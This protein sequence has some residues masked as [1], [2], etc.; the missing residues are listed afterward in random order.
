M[1]QGSQAVAATTLLN[2]DTGH[3]L[4]KVRSVAVIKVPGAHGWHSVGVGRVSGRKYA[5]KEEHGVQ[6]EAPMGTNWGSLLAVLRHGMQRSKTAR[7]RRSQ[8]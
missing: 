5:P 8:A 3:A 7:D 4:Q 1:G 2:V 6:T